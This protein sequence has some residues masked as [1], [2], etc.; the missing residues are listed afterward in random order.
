MAQVI[1]NCKSFLSFL[2]VT[3]PRIIIN[4]V[5]NKGSFRN[6]N[7]YE[8]SAG[9]YHIKVF[10]PYPIFMFPTCTAQ[11]IMTID[12][13]DVISV[14]YKLPIFIFLPGILVIES[15]K[16]AT[17]DNHKPISNT[18]HGQYISDICPHCKNPNTKRIR[19]CEWCGYQIH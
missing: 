4:G 8:L 12:H 15:H 9:T 1:I 16:K 7:I 5:Q 2:S 10:T 18:E 19:L 6:K 13:G 17:S 14:R 3:S 11:T